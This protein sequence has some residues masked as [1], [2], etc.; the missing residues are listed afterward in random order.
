MEVNVDRELEKALVGVTARDLFPDFDWVRAL[1]QKIH[2][3]RAEESLTIL[4]KAVLYRDVSKL[5]SILKIDQAKGFLDE[6]NYF[7][8]TP[9]MLALKAKRMDMVCVLIESG[10]KPIEGVEWKGDELLLLNEMV[11]ACID[12]ESSVSLEDLKRVLP[13]CKEIM[14]S[15]DSNG[16]KALTIAMHEGRMD[17]MLALLEVWEGELLD[18]DLMDLAGGLRIEVKS[19]EQEVE[20]FKKLIAHPKVKDVLEKRNQRGETPLSI[21]AKTGRPDFIKALIE[22]GED[23]HTRVKGFGTILHTL[24]VYL[25]DECIDSLKELLAIE[26]VKPLLKKKD[27]ED[28]TVLM[29]AAKVNRVDIDVLRTII[30]SGADVKTRDKNGRT[31]LHV[32]LVRDNNRIEDFESLLE[33]DQIKEI[34]EFCDNEGETP[35]IK[36]AKYGK[37]DY[38][39][40]LHNKGASFNARTVEKTP[41]E[42]RDETERAGGIQRPEGDT[43]IHLLF[44]RIDSLLNVSDWMGPLLEREDVKEILNT[45]GIGGKTALMLI[46]DVSGI[47]LRPQGTRNKEVEVMLSFMEKGADLGAQDDHGDTI[48]H[49]TTEYFLPEDFRKL[50]ASDKAKEALSV[51]NNRGH[52][53]LETAFRKG[54]MDVV[55]VFIECGAVEGVIHLALEQFCSKETFKVLLEI[56]KIRD[57][58]EEKDENGETALI[59]AMRLRQ[60]DKLQTLIDA[61]ADVTDQVGW[62]QLCKNLLFS[63]VS[64]GYF[65]YGIRVTYQL[66][67]RKVEK[68]FSPKL[69]RSVS[70]S[71]SKEL[72][73]KRDSA[74]SWEDGSPVKSLKK[75]SGLSSSAVKGK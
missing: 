2:E 1:G 57:R 15:K 33:L 32:L 23:S 42:K 56:E 48:L 63:L 26:E 55:K 25:E 3:N 40:A 73:R 72:K 65:G 44:D 54:K 74:F 21:A 39:L 20:D 41:L 16:T 18:T 45:K 59:K 36:A 49:K 43:A 61:G 10:A 66:V 6:K 24:V 4:H 38:M 22:M 70:A 47:R 68:A 64:F 67:M 14:G 28:N 71:P 29:R 58:R 5:R 13:A 11:L 9:L 50:L 12:D 27:G 31:I 30:Q 37:V 34:L 60:S 35:L 19:P 17:I 46:P 69:E 53:P 52:T 8:A 75:E 62:Y 7:G 51:K